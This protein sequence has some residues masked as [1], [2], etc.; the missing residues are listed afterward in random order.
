M[1]QMTMPRLE[2]STS[3]LA[4]RMNQML[5]EEFQLKLNKT[6]FWTD[7]TAV[8]QYIKNEDK[9]FYTFVANR[10]TVIHDGSEPSQWNYVPTNIN[11][12]DDVSL[13]LTAKELLN[14]VRWF[15][16]PEFLW[17]NETSWPTCPVSLARISDED[18]E[19]RDR[20]QVNHVTQM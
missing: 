16:G 13:R 10:L 6:V 9:R 2:L 15:R 4:V 8:L 17:E 7:S 5:Q 3:V 1:K 19:V 20:G 11:P 12:A 18:P 14:N